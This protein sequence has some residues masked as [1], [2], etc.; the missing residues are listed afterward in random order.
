M[1]TNL[2]GNP[3]STSTQRA[4]AVEVGFV[5]SVYQRVQNILSGPAPRQAPSMA[6]AA[7]SMSMGRASGAMGGVK[8]DVESKL[9][10]PRVLNAARFLAAAAAKVGLNAAAAVAP[11][12]LVG[13]YLAVKVGETVGE[14]LDAYL[15]QDQDNRQEMGPSL[16]RSPAPRMR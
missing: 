16:S 7:P 15:S 13:K 3:V 10:D 8:A 14:R 9:S 1:I 6:P 5:E 4:A 2:Y 12:G 11:G